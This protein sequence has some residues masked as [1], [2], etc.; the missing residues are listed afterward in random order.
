MPAAAASSTG[1]ATAAWCRRPHGVAPRSRRQRRAQALSEVVQD[2]RGH[3][4]RPPSSAIIRDLVALA[5]GYIKAD[6]VDVGVF[7]TCILGARTGCVVGADTA[8]ARSLRHRD[9]RRGTATR[10]KRG[11]EL[12]GAA[13]ARPSEGARSNTRRLARLSVIADAA[14]L[15]H[16][17]RSRQCE[18]LDRAARRGPALEPRDGGAHLGAVAGRRWSPYLLGSTRETRIVGDSVFGARARRSAPFDRVQPARTRASMIVK[19]VLSMLGIHWRAP[20]PAPRRTRAPRR[21]AISRRRRHLRWSVIAWSAKLLLAE[22]HRQRD[23][24]RSALNGLR[25]GMRHRS[26]GGRQER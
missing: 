4:A 2:R 14:G 12:R 6:L 13:R 3:V 18:G 5:A 23:R 19:W 21:C 8:R 17:V 7:W 26:R 24:A 10:S 11:V 9:R 25:P 20:S 1:T 15:V 16:L 22:E